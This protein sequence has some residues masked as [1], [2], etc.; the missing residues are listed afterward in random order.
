MFSMAET[1][2]LKYAPIVCAALMCACGCP[3][4]SPS[5]HS[6]PIGHT[7]TTFDVAPS[8]DAIVFNAAGAGGRDLFMMMLDDLAVTRV[9]ETPEYET[10]P[11]FS[12]DGKYL[13]YSAGVSGDRAD[14]VFMRPVS[15]GQAQ[16]LTRADANDCS[17]RFSPNGKLV[18]FARDK[19]YNWGG[20]AANWESGGVI[21]LVGS[22]GQNERQISPDGEFAGAPRFSPDGQSVIYYTP[23]GLKSVPI[24]G[25]AKPSRVM[26][27]PGAVPNRDWSEFAYAK[28]K[29]SSDTSIYV[30]NP[31]G[32]SNR[33][34][35]GKLGGCQLPQFDR[36]GH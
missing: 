11:S 36:K 22:D 15:G 35:T 9:A 32:S 16:Q 1:T 13:V 8:N 18:V 10:G 7:D 2:D 33:L 29:Y 12:E 4:E 14:H 19:T 25:S 23:T 34:L 5:G 30:T 6:R 20:L 17:P 28:G 3:L 26:K 27:E 24:D 21:C 31:D